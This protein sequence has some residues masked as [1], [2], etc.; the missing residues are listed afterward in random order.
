MAKEF[1]LYIR[2]EG[3]AKAA[4]TQGEHLAFI[5]QCEV[6]I[7]QLKAKKSLIA[8]QPLIREGC[9]LKKTASGWNN[10]PIDPTKETHVGYY[11]ILADN[12]DEAIEIAKQNPEFSFVPSATIEVRPLKTIEAATKFVYPR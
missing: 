12:I 10:T 1:M 11:H 6:Y 2:N 5:K 7:G 4:L 3:D 9:I 8:A